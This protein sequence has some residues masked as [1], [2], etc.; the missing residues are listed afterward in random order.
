VRSSLD[1]HF[2]Q[3]YKDFWSIQRHGQPSL[4]SVLNNPVEPSDIRLRFDLD[5]CKALGVEMTPDEL[6]SVYGTIVK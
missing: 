6:I 3:R 4:F 1:Q 2:D 5:I